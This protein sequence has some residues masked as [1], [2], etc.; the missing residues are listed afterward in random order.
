MKNAKKIYLD[1]SDYI[2]LL[3]NH[4][5]YGDILKYLEA[6]IAS[7]HI[8]CVFSWVNVV[9]FLQP[10]T[11]V[12]QQE[13]IHRAQFLKKI[14]GTNC[15]R[16]SNEI[17][18]FDNA[19]SDYGIWA[20]ASI[21][22]NFSVEEIVTKI[23]LIIKNMFPYLNLSNHEI[24]SAI[25]QNRNNFDSTDDQNLQMICD[26]DF[27]LAYLEGRLKSRTANIQLARFLS[28][29]EVFVRFGNCGA[30]LEKTFTAILHDLSHG[31]HST[32]LASIES[33]VCEKKDIYNNLKKYASSL[34]KQFPEYVYDI[35]SLFVYHNKKNLHL[36]KS[37]AGD[38][39]HALYIPYSHL[40]RGD[41]HFSDI[42]KRNN[43]KF[44]ERIVKSLSDLPSAIDHLLSK[45]AN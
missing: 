33:T 28:D 22:R 11:D 40:W 43:I 5:Q 17:K 24:A 26:N 41:K 21:I 45:K 23:R 29:L 42:L 19:I 25:K 1:T 30:E 39:L 3:Q 38:I 16:Y 20:P 18:K 2:N 27:F 36:Q 15:F 14:C 31:I 9:E 4:K 12:Y 37:D 35:I 32:I 34:L 44:S 6:Q 13:R 7:G 8:I 10:C